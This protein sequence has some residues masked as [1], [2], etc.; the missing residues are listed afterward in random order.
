MRTPTESV[1]YFL[2]QIENNFPT[3]HPDAKKCL[4]NLRL[5]YASTILMQTFVYDLIELKT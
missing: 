2:T 3:D 1:I 4:F 5:A